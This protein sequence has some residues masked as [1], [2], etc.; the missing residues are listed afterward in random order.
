MKI[1]GINAKQA[2]SRAWRGRMTG[3]EVL[4]MKGYVWQW[5][6]HHW[7]SSNR[8][9]QRLLA[10]GFQASFHRYIAK[11]SS[12]HNRDKKP[13]KGDRHVDPGPPFC[14]SLS[15]SFI[16]M[17]FHFLA[18]RLEDTFLHFPSFPYPPTVLSF[19]SILS[20]QLSHPHTQR[21]THS[22][23]AWGKWK[24]ATVKCISQGTMCKGLFCKASQGDCGAIPLSLTSTVERKSCH[25]STTTVLSDWITEFVNIS[26][27]SGFTAYKTLWS[28]MWYSL[29]NSPFWEKKQVFQWKNYS[30]S[31][32]FSQLSQPS[33]GENTSTCTEK[34]K[35]F[36]SGNIKNQS[37]NVKI[38]KKTSD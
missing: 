23:T 28:Q 31:T 33:W 22:H 24:P 37:S 9:L 32:L 21:H 4:G 2:A 18:H 16:L 34:N 27:G 19:L 5:R 8:G 35:L 7:G 26:P 20:T 13:S 10:V 38:G 14:R 15:H 30:S 11:K 17:C 12:I 29:Q 1:H 25:D 3:T 36:F 6:A